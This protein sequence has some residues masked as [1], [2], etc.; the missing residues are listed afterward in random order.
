[1]REVI[2]EYVFA[3]EGEDPVRMT[4]VYEGTDLTKFSVSYSDYANEMD[5][6]EGIAGMKFDLVT[7]KEK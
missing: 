3:L 2:G 1:M 5:E 6:L 4:L 7:A